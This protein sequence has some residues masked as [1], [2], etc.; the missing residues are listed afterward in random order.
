MFTGR[1]RTKSFGAGNPGKATS[2]TTVTGT[3]TSRLCFDFSGNVVERYRYDVFGAPTILSADNTPL[4]TSAFGNRFLFQGREYFREIGLYDYRHRFYDPYI[5]RFIQTDPPGLQTEGEKLSVGQKALYSPGGVAPDA[6]ATSEMNLFRY[7]GNDPVDGSDPLGLEVGFWESLIPVWG[8]GRESVEA[9]QTGHWVK[10][11]MLAVL[12]ATDVVPVKAGVTAL[13]KAG[14]KGAAKASLAKA[15]LKSPVVIGENMEQR[16]IPTA[17]KLAGHYYK[18]RG[19]YTIEKN[20]RWAEEMKR[21]I[22]RGERK[23]RDIGPDAQR[24][25]RSEAYQEER[26]IFYKDK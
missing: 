8:S 5:G 6:F 12:A 11:T 19:E 2:V 4:P 25:I 3:A 1:E 26:K 9:Y 14:I 23:L 20:K 13:A 7:C 24:N 17:E 10:G 22:N 21:Q 15:A 16:V 18:P